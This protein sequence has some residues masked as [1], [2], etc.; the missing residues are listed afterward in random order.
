MK[1]DFHVRICERLKLKCFGLLDH[2]K[3]PAQQ[4]ALAVVCHYLQVFSQFVLS[5]F[6][7]FV[8]MPVFILIIHAKPVKVNPDTAGAY[9]NCFIEAETFEL[10]EQTALKFIAAE[11]WKA[12]ALEEGYEVTEADYV[13]DPKGLKVFEQVSIDKEL[14]TFHTY[15][16]ND[17]EE[18]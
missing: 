12:I 13:D 10:A 6:F 15:E 1:G 18:N 3:I 11:N 2:Y 17:Q 16:T 5:V 14:Y 8:K 4:Q 7:D 9:V